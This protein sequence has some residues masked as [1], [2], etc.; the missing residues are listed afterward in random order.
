MVLDVRADRARS[1]S[2]QLAE[3][4]VDMRCLS[5]AEADVEDGLDGDLTPR[6]P[7]AAQMRGV[8]EDRRGLVADRAP[9]HRGYIRGH[10]RETHGLGTRQRIALSVMFG[11]CRK[12]GGSE[13]GDI[14]NV[15]E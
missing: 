3:R 7:P 5:E 13:L 8:T 15:D 12:D 2:Q 10:L 14:A 9:G 4:R 11:G 6:H 1:P